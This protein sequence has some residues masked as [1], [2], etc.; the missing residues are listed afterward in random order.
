M[1]LYLDDERTPPEG[2]TLVRWPANAIS[3]LQSGEVTELSLDHDLGNDAI[4]TGYDVLTWLEGQVWGQDFVPPGVIKVHSANPAVRIRM[5]QA[6]ASI[7][8]G[9]AFN[10]K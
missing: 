5:E 8:R 7:K 6:V 2:W 4:G 9:H 1:K 10:T 3:I